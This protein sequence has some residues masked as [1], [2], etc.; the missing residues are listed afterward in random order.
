MKVTKCYEIYTPESTEIGE[1]AE[2]GFM[3]IDM[4]FDQEDLEKELRENSYSWSN[5]DGPGWLI[6]TEPIQDRAYFERG[7]EKFYSL[8][9]QNA[10]IENVKRIMENDTRN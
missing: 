3:F 1:S 6:T 9:F 8:H 10:D 4:E 5:S 7:E 2:R